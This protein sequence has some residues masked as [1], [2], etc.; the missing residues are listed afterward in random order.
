MATVAKGSRL[1]A[2]LLAVLAAAS[3]GEYLRGGAIAQS[4]LFF[5]IGLG[6]AAV[7][8]LYR[9]PGLFGGSWR[10]IPATR[11]LLLY[12]CFSLA[13]VAIAVFGATLEWP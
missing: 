12:C 13:A 7:A 4:Y 2:F 5:A 8:E 10:Q 9:P 11:E 1:I 6:L 3:L